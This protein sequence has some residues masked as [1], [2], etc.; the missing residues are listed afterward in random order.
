MKGSR[1]GVTLIEVLVAAGLFAMVLTAI[2][3][4]YIEAAAVSAKRDEQ[5][6]RLRRFHLGLD[7][8]EQTLREG[9]VVSVGARLMT[10][11]KLADNPEVDGFPN[12]DRLP[13]QYVVTREGVVEVQGQEHKVV[14]KLES[15][16]TVVFSRVQ[17]APPMPPS[18]DLIRISLYKMGQGKRS[19][20]LFSRTL[21]QLKY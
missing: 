5:S 3:S 9:R 7:K 8:M 13:L 2:L 10:L 14:L 21:S 15:D 18:D 19:D 16:E 12:Y 11:I 4:F 17:Y 20:L 1:S 6:G